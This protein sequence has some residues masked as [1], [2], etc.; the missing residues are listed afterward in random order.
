LAPV[1]DNDW[2]A[3]INPNVPTTICR[4]CGRILPVTCFQGGE[5]FAGGSTCKLLVRPT[6]RQQPPDS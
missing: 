1:L 2:S 5:R 3:L 6:C 4:S